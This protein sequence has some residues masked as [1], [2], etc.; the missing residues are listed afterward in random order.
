[1]Q[2]KKIVL[3]FAQWIFIFNYSMVLIMPYENFHAARL[4]KPSKFD[5]Y[6]TTKGG[7][8]YNK[9]QVPKTI[10]II[11]GHLKGDDKDAWAPQSLH[12]NAEKWTTAEAKA[13]LKENEIKNIGFE[14]AKKSD[15]DDEEDEE[16]LDDEEEE[17]RRRR[18]EDDDEK[19]S[20]E[21]DED[22]EDDEC[23]DEKRRRRE[24]DNDD[25]EKESDDDEEKWEDEEDEE[26]RKR[27]PKEEK[28]KSMRH[29]TVKFEVK[30]LSIVK[31]YEIKVLNKELQS[32]DEYYQVK[33]YASTFGNID[34]GNDVVVEG[35]FSRSLKEFGVPALCWQHD[36]RDVVGKVLVCKEDG[37]G[38]YF[39]AIM[40]KGIE[41]FDKIYKLMK[42]NAI[43]S[44]S[45]GYS[46][47]IAD[48]DEE[49]KIR[50]LKDLDLYEC[51]FVTIPMNSEAKIT[52]CKHFNLS[53]TKELINSS[54]MRKT[55]SMLGITDKKLQESLYKRSLERF[56][57]ESGLF[58]KQA[59]EYMA[60]HYKEWSEPVSNKQSETVDAI[61]LLSLVKNFNLKHT[62]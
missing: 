29:S 14:S 59:A 54:S 4:Q 25:E 21:E 28:P 22:K 47:K 44:M 52:G 26:K 56:L 19:E 42:I 7:K 24:E 34:R 58:S 48:P 53:N 9:I 35:A 40:P 2:L 23:E 62:K 31:G 55:L 27:K 18:E 12:F 6:R 13:W 32:D 11:W 16:K 5:K 61:S 51:S 45:I 33:G 36:V 60:N 15:S 1:L 41:Q 39:E 3:F 46:I 17:K 49:Q 50:Y 43:H 38:L 30:N 8:L 37:H 57:I 20:D 10:E